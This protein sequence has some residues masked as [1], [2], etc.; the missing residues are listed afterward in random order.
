[1]P[2]YRRYYIQNSTVF[3]TTITNER[4]Q[5]LKEE[6]DLSLFFDTLKQVQKIHPFHLTAYVILPDHFHFLMNPGDSVGNFSVIV[7]SIKWNYTFEYKK[8]HN[9]SS[10]LN[11][12]QKRFWD[13]VI[14]DEQ[15]FKNHFDYIHWNPVKH[16]YVESPADWEYSTFRF[17]CERGYYLP[18]SEG[19][20]LSSLLKMDFE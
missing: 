19:V 7:K 15:D 1:M 17:W 20:E 4:I 18:G 12:W 9:I 3:I 5:F 11:F 16:G 10:P 8:A 13:H 2:D 14:R 6:H